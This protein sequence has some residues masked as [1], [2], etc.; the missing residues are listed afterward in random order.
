MFGGVNREK[1]GM[2]PNDMIV[3]VRPTHLAQFA[4]RRLLSAAPHR[5]LCEAAH[6]SGGHEARIARYDF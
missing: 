4:D 6:C 2:I 3:R 5:R 1:L